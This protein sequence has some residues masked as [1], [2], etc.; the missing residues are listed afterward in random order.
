MPGRYGVT[1]VSIASLEILAALPPPPVQSR[2]DQPQGPFEKKRLSA[3]RDDFGTLI[4]Y[5]RDMTAEEELTP[6]LT[7]LRLTHD[8][9]PF[10]EQQIPAAEAAFRRMP[11]EMVDV[12]ATSPDFLP[13]AP[14][15]PPVWLQLEGEEGSNAVI[16][17]ARP[18][19][20]GELW[21]I[22]PT[23]MATGS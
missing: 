17:V 2:L 19:A 6:A 4:I 1:V 15:S 14:G 13:P 21:I 7:K 18:M 10:L 11:D 8:M 3:H 9:L 12:L 22:A 20:D 16:I 23:K 5:R